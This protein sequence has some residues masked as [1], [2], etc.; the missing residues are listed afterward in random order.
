MRR[1]LLYL[2]FV[3]LA[4]ALEGAQA[5]GS[6]TV[7]SSDVAEAT[8]LTTTSSVTAS[9][10]LSLHTTVPGDVG[11]TLEIEEVGASQGARVT[12]S[13]STLVEVGGQTKG[14]NG[15]GRAS[16]DPA[17]RVSLTPNPRVTVLTFF[18]MAPMW[19]M[20]EAYIESERV[21]DQLQRAVDFP[22][23]REW[24]LSGS[25]HIEAPP[26]QT[27]RPEAGFAN[28]PHAINQQVADAYPVGTYG[29]GF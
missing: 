21:F 2:A 1:N 27:I 26:P 24:E 17:V 5:R 12:V 9:A 16:S 15:S 18:P 23:W 3:L 4:V 11:I 22:L 29:E 10:A 25:E 19:L 14:A 6:L 20:R 13:V 8:T 28:A 7:P